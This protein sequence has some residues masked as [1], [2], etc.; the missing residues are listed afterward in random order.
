MKGKNIFWIIIGGFFLLLLWLLRQETKKREVAEKIAA[1][2]IGERDFYKSKYLNLLE[3]KLIESD[4]PNEI[5]KELESLMNHFDKID[6]KVHEQLNT[7]IKLLNDGYKEKAILDLTKVIE[8]LLKDT[9]E[10]I[11]GKK[12]KKLYQ[13]LEYARDKNWIKPHEFA[14][15]E[16]IRSIRNKEGHELNNTIDNRT[17]YLAIFSGIE[18]IYK[19]PRQ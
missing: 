14:F 15:S 4:A 11:E 9:F 16:L 18:I 2:A 7:I 3:S 12:G 6:I 10:K 19:I 13:L 17:A 5:I 1:N 8:N